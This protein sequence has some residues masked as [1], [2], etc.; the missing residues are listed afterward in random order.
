M[1]QKIIIALLAL[2]VLLSACSSTQLDPATE[3]TQASEDYITYEELKEITNDLSEAFY[4]F[5]CNIFVRNTDSGVS[6]SL[7]MKC[8][9]V[10][11]IFS[12]FV[13]WFSANVLDLSEEYNIPI[14]KVDV[15]FF[16]TTT[17]D[18]ITWESSDGK[19]GELTDLTSNHSIVDSITP[20]EIL[21][22]YG[23]AGLEFPLTN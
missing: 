22:K 5:D 1:Q 12:D 21:E 18:V 20:S 3:S 14:S 23:S 2:S 19:A 10:P 4:G 15:S 17:N 8:Y 9:V 6:F 13:V 16:D 11:A 7:S